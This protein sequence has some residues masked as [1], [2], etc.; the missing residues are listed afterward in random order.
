MGSRKF[1]T[2][3]HVA[4]KRAA[5]GAGLGLFATLPLKKGDF[6]AEYT[7][8]LLTEEES[9]ARGGK[10][11][12]DAEDGWVLDGK[13]RTCVAHFINHS[14]RPNCEAFAEGKRVFIYAIRDIAPGEEIGCDYGREYVEKF[15]KPYGCKCAV[16]HTPDAKA[17]ARA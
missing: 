15:I 17:P 6:I 1:T 9:D 5:R 4:V 11:L 3:P 8:E 13:D 2:P 16:C 14:C 10:Y 12:M 7:G